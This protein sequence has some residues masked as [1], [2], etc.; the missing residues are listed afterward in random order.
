EI[1]PMGTGEQTVTESANQETIIAPEPVVDQAQRTDEVP[2]R[3]IWTPR[4]I[5]IFA[6]ILVVGLSADSLLVQAR[7]NGYLAGNGILLAHLTPIF[8]M[9][10]VIIVQAR[11]VWIRLGGIFGCIW[12]IFSAINLIITLHSISP[13]APILAHLDAAF[14][15]AL[16]GCYICLS[17]EQIPLRRWDAWFFSIAPIIVICFVT[18][19][20]FLTPADSR[21][22]S[23]IEDAIAGIANVLSV[24]IWWARPSCWKVVPGLTFLFG[25]APLIILLLSIPGLADSDTNFFFG[26]VMLL[27]IL[28]GTIRFLQS[29]L[30]RKLAHR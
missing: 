9:W 11:S 20:F 23:T 8:I 15:S 14:S 26:E 18:G 6:L 16:L 1:E 2:I 17:I 30:R 25:I 21:S 19:L 27:C 3:V 12:A 10:V 22:F 24:L 4:F 29:E 28:L 7:D 5:V 13:N